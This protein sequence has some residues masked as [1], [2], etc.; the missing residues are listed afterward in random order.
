V[1]ASAALILVLPAGAQQASPPE[2][3]LPP[4]P[5][6]ILGSPDLIATSSAGTN[7][8]YLWIVG[9]REHVVMLCEKKET[10]KDFS[11]VSK[12]LP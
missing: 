9:P 10:E 6:S 8:S 12:R 7:G 2:P 3:R 11:C 4:G 5:S 1:A